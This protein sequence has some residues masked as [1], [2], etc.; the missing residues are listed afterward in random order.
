[1]KEIKLNLKGLVPLMMHNNQAVD[2]LNKYYKCMK[3]LSAKRNKTEADLMELGRIEWEA[4]LYVSPQGKICIPGRNIEKSFILGARK[5]K[6]GKKFE[7]GVYLSDDYCD[8]KFKD[9]GVVVKNLDIPSSDL[10]KLYMAEHID[11]RAVTVSRSTIIRTRPIFES[12]ELSCTVLYDEN[13]LN[14]QTLLECVDVAGKYVGLCEMRP[15]LG[16]FEIERV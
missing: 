5:S 2:P 16:R 10:D 9:N 4:G 15:R 12:W 13:V 11:R 6:N 8:L 1:M 7:E 3:P 14:G